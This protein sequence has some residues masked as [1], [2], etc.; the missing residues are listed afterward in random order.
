MNWKKIS[1]T[2]ASLDELKTDALL[3]PD[4]IKWAKALQAISQT[5]LHFTKDR[6]DRERYVTIGEIA[7]EI[8]AK[9]SNLKKHEYLDLFK[10]EVGYAT[11]KVDV[12]AAIFQKNKILLVE[13]LLDDRRWTLPGGWADVNESPSESIRRETFE[14][15]GFEVDVKKIIAVYDRTS[16][17]HTPHYPFHVYKIFFLCEITGGAARSSIETGRIEFFPEDGLPELSRGRITEQQ[18]AMCFEHFRKPSLPT[19]FD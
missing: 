7:A 9:H 19:E 15:S 10:D 2:S 5:G 16:H 6:F 14:E 1:L 11:P 3:E 18:V 8:L 12:R 4:W 13:E 17:G